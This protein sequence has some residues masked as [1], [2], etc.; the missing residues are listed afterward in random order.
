MESESSIESHFAM[1]LL[2]ST[3]AHE[4]RNPLQSVRLEI[5]M[6]RRQ[7]RLNEALDHIDSGLNRIESVVD[8]I[9]KMGHQ[10]ELHLSSVDL[11]DLFDSIFS[12]MK[13]WLEA[14]GIKV[15][16][17]FHWEGRP[18]I[19]GDRE[20][21]EQVFINLVTNAVQAMPDGGGL[22][23][24]VSECEREAEIEI[25]DTGS[26]MDETARRY[27]GTPFFTTKTRGNGLGVAFCKSIVSLHR[28]RIELESQEGEGTCVRVRLPKRV[29]E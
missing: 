21:L 9:Q 5:E 7:G 4:I 26:G 29:G 15:V 2:A 20:L 3:L 25:Y 16:Q 22:S 27:F 13:F 11:K 23:I 18:Q 12:T 8:R 14:S 10:Y 24:S 17:K 28:G 19:Q 6:A 1:N